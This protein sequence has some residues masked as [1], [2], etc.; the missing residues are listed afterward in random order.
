MTTPPPHTHTHTN[1]H[2]QSLHIY[3]MKSSGSGTHT[4]T[5][6]H[7]HTHTHTHITHI[8]PVYKSMHCLP[9]SFRIDF[10]ILLL[11][12]TSLH[13]HAPEYIT[14]MLSRYTPSRSLRSSGTE[15]LTV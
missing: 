7:T 9:V 15:L 10:K 12:Y 2:A 1:T 6:T 4:H 8:T 5:D 13:S 14:D 11:V 3:Q